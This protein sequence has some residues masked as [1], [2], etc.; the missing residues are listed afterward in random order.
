MKIFETILSRNITPKNLLNKIE[1]S[2]IFFVLTA[3]FK[4]LKIFL[5]FNSPKGGEL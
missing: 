1:K 2:Q 5:V 3:Y 4:K